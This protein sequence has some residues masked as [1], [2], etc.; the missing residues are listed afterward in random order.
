[1]TQ[2]THVAKVQ[3][4]FIAEIE[5]N[6]MAHAL[7]WIGGW[8]SEMSEARVRDLVEI[9]LSPDLQSDPEARELHAMDHLMS[10]GRSNNNYSSSVGANLSR[11]ALVA[12][13]SNALDRGGS[14]SGRVGRGRRWTA[15]SER[16]SSAESAAS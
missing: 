12:A 1:M 4:K 2:N 10:L 16:M 9:E 8:Y 15:V 11:Q 13:F 5:K 6:G 3:A 14:V 7:E